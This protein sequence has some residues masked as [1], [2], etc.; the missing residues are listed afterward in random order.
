MSTYKYRNRHYDKWEVA[1][2]VFHDYFKDRP[3][4]MGS[5]L[6]SR[7]TLAGA[8]IT[9]P[10]DIPDGDIHRAYTVVHDWLVGDTTPFF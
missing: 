7:E 1:A 8:G 4:E 6:E 10:D 5:Y 9:F 3:H 2:D